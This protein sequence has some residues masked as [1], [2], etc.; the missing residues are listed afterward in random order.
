MLAL[1]L[2]KRQKWELQ[3]K[4]AREHGEEWVQD[5]GL[6]HPSVHYPPASFYK[7]AE[8]EQQPV[9]SDVD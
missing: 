1:V 5:S 4:F 6:V 8:Q 3:D 7:T 2:T 9:E